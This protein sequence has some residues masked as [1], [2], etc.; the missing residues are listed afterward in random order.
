[1][2]GDPLEGARE[3]LEVAREA[4]DDANEK[5]EQAGA[6]AGSGGGDKDSLPTGGVDLT[7]GSGKGEGPTGD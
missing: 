5:L 6:S 1:M 7:G 3:H 2:S 4:I